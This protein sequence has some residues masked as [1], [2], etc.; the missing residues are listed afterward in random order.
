MSANP[1]EH[2]PGY[3]EPGTEPASRN[4]AGHRLER[5]T[6]A[7]NSVHWPVILF[8]DKQDE[9]IETFTHDLSSEGFFCLSSR[10]FSPGETLTCAMRVPSYD[11]FGKERYRVLECHVRVVRSH[12][13]SPE[14][15]YG[16]ACR[17]EH[18]RLI[19]GAKRPE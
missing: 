1:L 3:L 10:P 7:R 2:F 19:D 12:P 15:N 9:A 5:R 16:V 13:A 6:R 17:I 14:G 4:G 11:A 8:G 18:Y